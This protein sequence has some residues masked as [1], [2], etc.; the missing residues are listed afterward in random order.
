M[1]RVEQGAD[2]RGGGRRVRVSVEARASSCASDGAAA[3]A[4]TRTSGELLGGRGQPRAFEGRPIL[5]VFGPPGVGKSAVARRLLVRAGPLLE[6]DFRESLVDA[7]R[8][9]AWPERLVAAPALLFDGLECL[10][11]RFGAVGMLV[12][13]LGERARAGRRT[14]LCQGADESLREVARQLDCGVRATLLL[15]FPVGRGRRQYVHA[16]A[17]HLGVPWNEARH[18]VTMEP[19]SYALVEAGLGARRAADG[20]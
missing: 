17:A 6:V 20:A 18:L 1:E 5:F 16:R 10:E 4:I 2:R 11:G 15:R 9:G 19:W 12:R 13:L 14:V 3:A 8:R 7:V